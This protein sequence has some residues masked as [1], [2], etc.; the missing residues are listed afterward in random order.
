[1]SDTERAVLGIYWMMVNCARVALNSTRTAAN[2]IK[3]LEE[4]ASWPT[5][6][7]G[8]VTDYVD[9]MPAASITGVSKDWS[10]VD[11][12][13]DPPARL[14]ITA[15]V[16]NG[17]TSATNVEDAPSTAVLITRAWVNDIP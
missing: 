16:S 11:P 6:A 3:F 17:F 1:M 8:N 14:N 4:A 15:S 5:D 13:T 2:R 9:A 10:W 7:N 12:E